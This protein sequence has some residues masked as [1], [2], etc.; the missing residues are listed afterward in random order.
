MIRSVLQVLTDSNK[1]Y[2]TLQVFPS[3]LNVH[4]RYKNTIFLRLPKCSLQFFLLNPCMCLLFT[5]WLVFEWVNG[6]CPG[7]KGQADSEETARAHQTRLR[8][9]ER[10]SVKSEEGSGD[11]S[12]G[13]S[14]SVPPPL[15]S[16]SC[17]FSEIKLQYVCVYLRERKDFTME[18]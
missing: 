10:S 2:I 17:L 1:P 4:V 3:P 18:R 12:L 9:T 15:P 7:Y 13:I 14:W 11:S 8:Q 5:C 6:P 16:P